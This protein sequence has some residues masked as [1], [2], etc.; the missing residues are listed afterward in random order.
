MRLTFLLLLML[1]VTAF[2]QTDLIINV[3]GRNTTSLNGDWRYIPDLYESG[4]YDYRYKESPNGF[5]QDA[6]PQ[7]KSDRIEYSFDHADQ[8]NVPGDWNSQKDNLFFYESTIWYRKL[9]DY[10][11]KP[12]T[13][14]FVYF[15]AANYE[16]IVYLNG[17]KLGKHIGG[18]TPFNFEITDHVKPKDNSLIIKVDNKRYRKAVP[19]V[20]TDWW[21]YGGLTRR[22]MLIETPLTF[23]QDYHIQLAKGSQDRIEGWVKVNGQAASQQITVEIPKAGIKETVNT[24][25]SGKA[26]VSFKADLE[27]WSP[28][29]PTL[30]NVTISSETDQVTDRIGFRTIETRGTELLLNGEPIFLR[31]ICQHEVKALSGGRAYSREN[32][33]IIMNWVKQLNGN[34]MR[35]AHYPHNEYMARVADEKGILLWEEIPVYWT[36][37][38][39]N[40]ATY[41]NAENQLTELI[42]RDRNR[43][44]VI[45]WSMANET[46]LSEPRLTFLTNLATHTRSLDNTRLI[47]AAME[48]HYKKDG[49]TLLIDDPFG[50]VVDVLGCNEYIGWYDGL[51]EKCTRVEWESAYNKPL[52]MSEFGGGALYGYHGDKLTRWSEEFQADIYT[53]QIKMLEDI[54]FLR[55]TT[56]WI[57]TDFRSPR[58]VLADI[59]DYYNRKGLISEKGLKKQAYFVLQKWYKELAEKE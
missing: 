21:N 55:G 26:D 50:K 28:E 15:G 44:S 14:L 17:E 12:E 24:N 33:E 54:P 22:V 48:R 58:R 7:K 42:S 11:K 2:T 13:R 41:E 3:D 51:P 29:N 59:Q 37:L 43:A 39:E 19:T 46:P 32:A 30:Y 52:I 31:G 56:P 23:I 16:A 5:F 4:Y 40:E 1:V 53:Q 20:N 6:E 35:L 27:L 34:F 8:L 38:W 25:A 49:K 10:N 36:I 9:F 45:L 18:F 47:T 57:L